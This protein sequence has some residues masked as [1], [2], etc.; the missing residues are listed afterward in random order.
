MFVSLVEAR[1]VVGSLLE[2]ERLKEKK[3][4]EEKGKVEG[5]KKEEEEGEKKGDDG[6]G[7]ED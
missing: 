5:E 7:G 1:N 4:E 2:R 3:E 6:A